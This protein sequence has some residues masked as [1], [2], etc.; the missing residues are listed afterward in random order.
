MIRKAF[1]LAWL[2]ALQLLRN[3]AE[4]VGVIV[5]PLA[6]TF[7][8]GSAFGGG[9]AKPMRVLLVDEDASTYSAQVGE[10]LDAEA[11]LE[12][13]AVTRQEAEDL[14]A[15]GDA[16]VAVLVPEGFGDG[17]AS[18]SSEIE[19]LKDPASESAFAV[20][21]VVQ[22]I[23]TRISGDA[24]TAR[25]V[26]AVAPSAGLSFDAVHEDV[27]ARWDPKP[28]VYAEGQTVVASDVRGDSVLA[29]SGTLSS[30]GFTVWFMLFMTFGSAGGILE[31]REQGTLRRLL[32]A[33][34]ERST[35]IAGKVLGI[36]LA[37][38]AQVLVLVLVG[39]LVFGV[40]WGRDPLAVAMVLAAYILAGTGIAVFVSAV[41]RTRDQ[42]GGLAPIISTGFAMLGGCMW[43]IEVVSPFMQTVAKLTPTGWAVMG[44]TDV[45]A[46]NQGVGA[47]LVPTLVLLG[48]AVV[49]IGLGVRFLKFE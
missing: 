43:P 28:P 16:S 34:V 30:I 32:V 18:G 49:S 27:D 25:V 17:L 21:S 26:M 38:T 3:P 24:G 44:L 2:N 23:A 14:I 46:R 40:P 4:V 11:S 13:D 29:S 47:A 5:L 7:L 42:L 35:I 45:V 6:L 1:A 15:D 39:A 41:V 33:P 8:F 10:L 48:I 22:G 9:E 37:A 36:V 12:T 20:I 31:E 19:V